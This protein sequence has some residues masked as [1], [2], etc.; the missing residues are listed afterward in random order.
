MGG[1]RPLSFLLAAVW[2]AAGCATGHDAAGNLAPPD[3]AVPDAPA[4]G[5][6]ASAAPTPP[7]V[8]APAGEAASPG[9]DRC[10]VD[11]RRLLGDELAL[12]PGAGAADLY[13]LVH[14]AILGPGP[15][16]IGDGAR[17]A[18][19]RELAAAGPPRDGEAIVEDLDERQGTVRVNLRRWRFIRATADEL[20]PILE[21]SVRVL[22]EGDR[23]RLAACLAAAAPVLATLGRDAAEFRAF[24]AAREAEGFPAVAPGAEFREAHGPSYR[25]V[26]RRFLPPWVTAPPP[27]A[28]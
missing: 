21:R 12:R 11:L 20:W 24:V 10:G 25:V 4:P 6:A 5:P 9:S 3:H 19:A 1:M 7:P 2:A 27:E 22:G 26:L 18:L 8:S 15:A 16:T 17:E 14:E 13:R 23:D 28:G